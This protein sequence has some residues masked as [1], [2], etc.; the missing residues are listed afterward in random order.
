MWDIPAASAPNRDNA[1]SDDYIPSAGH[2]SWRPNRYQSSSTVHDEYD[3]FDD[4]THETRETYTKLGTGC[5][6][7]C[8]AHALRE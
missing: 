3:E 6:A 5:V 8:Q 4:E 1:L 2:A 7:P